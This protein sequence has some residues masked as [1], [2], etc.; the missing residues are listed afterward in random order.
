MPAQ[1]AI[2]DSGCTE[3]YLTTDVQVVAQQLATPPIVISLP[4]GSQLSS[5]HTT[6][7]PI[8]ASMLPPAAL[9]AHI[10]PHLMPNSLISIGQLCDA[11]CTAMLTAETAAIRFEGTTVLTGHRNPATRLWQVELNPTSAPSTVTAVDPTIAP[12][13]EPTIAPS[14]MPS[15]NQA[16]A[17][18]PYCNAINPAS[19]I[20]QRIAYYHACCFSP[21]L[22][23]WC[24]AIDAGRFTTWPELTSKLV[25]K[26]PPQSPAM[27]KGHLDQTRA[28]VQS[29]QPNSS[30]VPLVSVTLDSKIHDDF[31]PSSKPSTEPSGEPPA[32]P[33]THAV[34]VSCQPVS[35][36]VFSD[37]TGRFLLPS[38]Q[39]NSHL[40]VVYDYDSNT[41]FAEPM[42]SGTGLQ[43]TKAYT[44]VHTLLTKRGLK[45]QLKKLDNEA[46][47]HLKDFLEA[48]QVDFQLV[49]PHVHRRNAAE[50]AIRTFK[51]H[52]IAGLCSVDPDFPLHL[53]DRLLPQALLTLNLLR[54]SR[55]NPQLSAYAQ[56]H[57]AFDFNRTPVG[58]PGTR[59]LV[60][61]TPSVRETWAPHAA[62]AWYI[63][64]AMKHYRCFNTWVIETRAERIAD[65]IVWFPSQVVMPTASSSDA[66]C[67]AALDLIQ[68]LRHPATASALSPL[69]DAE[70]AALLQLA[71]IFTA[72]FS[73]TQPHVMQPVPLPLVAPTVP[74]GFLPILPVTTPVTMPPIPP[75]MFGSQ[76]R[77]PLY[78]AAPAAI[79]LTGPQPRVPVAIVTGTDQPP[80]PPWIQPIGHTATP[81]LSQL[82]SHPASL[83]RTPPI[84]P[85]LSHPASLLR[86]QSTSLPGCP[87]SAPA[88]PTNRVRLSEDAKP[89]SPTT[90]YPRIP[91]PRK[92]GTYASHTTNPGQ[93]RRRAQQTAVPTAD[94]FIP[95][96]H[97]TRS[98]VHHAANAVINVQHDHS[99]HSAVNIP[100]KQLVQGPDAIHWLLATSK[101][102]GRLAQGLKDVL[103]GT[104]T[105][106]FIPH[107]A[108][109]TDRKATYLRI[110]AEHKPSKPDP[111]RIRFT[112]GGDKVEYPGNVSTPTVDISTV[113]CH[114]NSV[115]STPAARYMT[116]DLKDFYL[117]TPLDRYEYMR[118]PVTVIPPDIMEQYNLADLVEGGFV[119][120]E[121]R[122]GIYG[123]PQAGILANDLLLIRLAGGGY[124]PAPHT[125]GLFL[126]ES[127][128]L[129]FTLWVDD[130]GVKY[131]EKQHVVDL[132]ELLRLY[133]TMK[134]DW[135]GALYLGVTLKWDYIKRTVDLSMPGYIERAL[136]RFQHPAPVRPQH[137]PHAWTPPQ[138]GAATQLTD[139]PDT[140]PPLLPSG[141]TLLQQII[142]VLLYYA[143][144]LDSTMLVTLGTL[145][146]AQAKG[147]EATMQA[148]TQLLNYC[149]TH[150]DATIRFHASGMVLHIHSDA[151]YLSAS[152]AR[153]RLGG[154]FFLSDNVGDTAPTPN[155]QPPTFNAPV[156][157][158]SAI[159]QSILSS[160]AEAELGALFY[161]A[162]DGCMLRN[163]F[164]DLGHPQPPT[165]IQTDNACAA[166]IAN[167]TVKQKRSKAIDMRLYWVRDRVRAKEFMVYWRRGTDNDADYFTKHHSPT[168]HRLKRSRY[169]YIPL[170]ST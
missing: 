17:H 132:L 129:S 49:P 126:H 162:K 107:S 16:S 86:R 140:S 1:M 146:S 160:A 27:V 136:R 135:T 105:M 124:Y 43:H 68:A 156:L 67:A 10:V 46:S 7:L 150:P 131:S 98:R 114:L 118:I 70:H 60:L 125:P 51:N 15:A 109:P 2:L 117:N 53:W 72:R 154:Y 149:A 142:G 74:P 164:L 6:S 65:T 83:R 145:A 122:K 4:D 169:L 33:R 73:G 120:V 11:G 104:D 39:G 87:P 59:V 119:M 103:P 63:G 161:N 153:S 111:Y 29:T 108:K 95:H 42:P 134:V 101:E 69:A 143:R 91:C 141:I 159:I 89:C 144:I 36:Q 96:T 79:P 54:G 57:G 133:Y 127:R 94:I 24:T 158:N 56:I 62:D 30:V 78:P 85:P 152:G 25:R 71:D 47:S 115:L 61:E 137:S 157:V 168:H 90:L 84:I 128:P 32:V 106:F 23:T 9:A 38:S 110:V 82:P 50:R 3:H 19:T 75:A 100:H 22:S 147:T 55:I 121:I 14:F 26:Y 102:I 37:A 93:R 139:A 5:S 130:F 97:G 40:L 45:P 48:E 123:L 18:L 77:V 99:A 34:Y 92:P 167:N 81:P 66:A 88:A 163:T 8:I 20:A 21:A 112:A 64:P 41:I 31:N 80:R 138:F 166:G 52:F 44:R 58:P 165:P 113:K 13:T 12:A 116:V 76:P 28:N 35:G 148:A 155:S 170:V 151:S